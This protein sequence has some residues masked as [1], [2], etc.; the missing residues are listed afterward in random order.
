MEFSIGGY[1]D[2]LICDVFPMDTC[3]LLLGRPWQYE[4]GV[5]YDEKENTISFMKDGRTFKIQSLT[6]EE[7]TQSKIPSFLLR[8]GK[9]FI[10]ILQ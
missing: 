6:E 1:K 7:K 3:H 9:E 8:S 5:I 4:K 2:K 10:N